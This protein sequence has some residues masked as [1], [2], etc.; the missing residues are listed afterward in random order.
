MGE[1]N[2]TDRQYIA[3]LLIHGHLDA[4]ALHERE[5]ES[6]PLRLV[7]AAILQLG[8]RAMPLDV[9][10]VA[11]QMERSG[12]LEKVGGLEFLAELALS[13]TWSST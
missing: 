5:I 7:R 12:S 6:Q 13:S 11:D 8:M 1:V 4:R 3:D 9:I 2:L 10:T